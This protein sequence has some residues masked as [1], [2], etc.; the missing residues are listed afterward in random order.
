MEPAFPAPALLVYFRFNEHVHLELEMAEDA[1]VPPALGCPS[2]PLSRREPWYSAN[3]PLNVVRCAGRRHV[4]HRF[5][6]IR[7]DHHRFRCRKIGPVERHFDRHT[8]LCCCWLCHGLTT[9]GGRCELRSHAP[10]G[11]SSFPGWCLTGLGQPSLWTATDLHR[12]SKRSTLPPVKWRRMQEF[13]LRCL[14]ADSGFQSRCLSAR[15]I[16]RVV[17]A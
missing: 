8:D 15:P 16:L 13:H 3:P 12:I 6:D 5:A 14:P 4:L 1:G 11:D 17:R 9:N 2:P 7:R 10:C